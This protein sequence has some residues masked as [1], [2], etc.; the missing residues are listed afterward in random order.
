LLSGFAA[1]FEPTWSPAALVHGT[2]FIEERLLRKRRPQ[3]G[4]GQKVFPSISTKRTDESNY[5]KS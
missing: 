4:T 5:R 3:N 1:E 2:T